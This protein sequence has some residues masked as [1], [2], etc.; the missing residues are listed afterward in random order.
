LVE[1]VEPEAA[2]ALAA[3]EERARGAPAEVG[4]QE[5]HR[6]SEVELAEEQSLE[7]G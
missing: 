4:A 6:V 1:A 5:E 2:A 3:L 7:N